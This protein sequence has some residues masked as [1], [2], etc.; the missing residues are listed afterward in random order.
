[1][2]KKNEKNM[3]KKTKKM[4]KKNEKNLEFGLVEGNIH[5]K[6]ASFMGKLDGLPGQ[7]FPYTNP[8]TIMSA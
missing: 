1:M 8:M 5:Q 2:K 7:I 3:K 6:T 4:R